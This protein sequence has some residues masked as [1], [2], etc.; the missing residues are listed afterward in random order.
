MSKIIGLLACLTVLTFSF[1]ASGAKLS[2]E[3]LEKK[4]E[5]WYPTGLPLINFTTDAGLGYGLRLYGYNNG[6]P[7]DPHYDESPYFMRLYG[8]FFQTT[9]GQSYHRVDLDMP[10]LIGSEYRLKAV[11]EYVAVLNANYFGDTAADADR[12]LGVGGTYFNDWGSYLDYVTPGSSEVSTAA[13]SLRMFNNYQR[14]KFYGL[15]KVSRPFFDLIEVEAGLEF[16]YVAITDWHDKTGTYG[17]VEE[18]FAETRLTLAAQS[19]DFIGYDGGWVNVLHFGLR[20]DE[21]DFEPNPK[22]G[23]LAEYNLDI[24]GKFLGSNYDFVRQTFSVRG[25]HTFWDR[26]TLAGRL[27]MT[28]ASGDVPFF[29]LG[30]MNFTNGTATAM[31]GSRTNRGYLEERFLARGYT[32]AQFD[33]RYFVGEV[34][35]WGQRFGLQPFA[36]IDVGNVYDTFGD[37]FAKP[38]FG[39]YRPSYG[40]GF[41][42]PWNLTTIVHCFAG[43]SSEGIMTLSMNFEHAF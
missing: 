2:P 27:A 22:T 3:D 5:G 28:Y 25:F 14:R 20:I 9:G 12:G 31:G 4:K 43:F 29:E 15:L 11:L 32:L 19:D 1:G 42:V 36:F 6:L 24:S 18:T 7:D 23:Y 16:G 33:V 39:E 26:L 13:T 30:K 41:V 37:I 38:R 40:G 34:V 8:Q 10:Y 35:V 21:R 17:D